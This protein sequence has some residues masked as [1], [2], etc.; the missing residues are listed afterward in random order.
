MKRRVAELASARILVVG[1]V[2]LDRYW[3]GSTTRVSPEAPVPIVRVTGVEERVGGAANVAA[4]A[5]ALGATVDLVGVTGADPESARL[6]ALCEAAGVGAHFR[7]VADWPTFVKLRVVSQNQQLLRLDFEHPPQAAAPVD[8]AEL[9]AAR[10][11]GRGVLVLSDYGKGALSGVAELITIA[12]RHGMRVVVDPKGRDFVRY[13]GADLITPNMSEFE[14]VVGRCADESELVQK[15]LA[16]CTECR[17][18][19]ILVTRSE[20]GMSLVRPGHPPLHLHAEARDVYDVTGAGDT[21]CATLATAL[22]AGF[23]MPD[24]IRLANTAAGIV[25]GKLGTAV[26][27][28]AELAAALHAHEAGERGVVDRDELVRRAGLARER[29]E[30]IVMTNGCFDLL[31]AGH[32]RYLRA[33]AELGDRLIVA[34]NS[35]DSVRRLKGAGR[36]LNPL[37]ERME[38]LA[39]LA[40]VD[41]VVPF[42]A[43]TPRD[44]IAAVL[45]DVL[46]KG[47]DY[48]VAQIA[49]ATEVLAAG[50]EVLTLPYHAG[51]STTNI[52]SNMQASDADAGSAT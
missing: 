43:E 8:F 42:D 44:L 35:D 26:I 52:I 9:V 46:V 23:D 48:V 47:G 31:H 17:F 18:A 19:A 34:V 45:P 32:V 21:V 7:A 28:N 29:G 33:A 5:A 15:A 27:R 3:S 50:G 37:A 51:L 2:M 20:H 12:H 30:R 16:L 4:N 39:A 24:A 49:G 41:W 36:P 10:L 25:V 40:G 14:A 38:V 22:A 13:S 6:A 1:D 11:T